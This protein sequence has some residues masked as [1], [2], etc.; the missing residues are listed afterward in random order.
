MIRVVFKADKHSADSLIL[1]LAKSGV[2]VKC[3][4]EPEKMIT[5]G[6]VYIYAEFPDEVLKEEQT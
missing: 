3:F 4:Q 6:N 2:W 1:G 5:P